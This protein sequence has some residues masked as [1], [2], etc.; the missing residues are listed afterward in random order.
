M[1]LKAQTVIATLAA[2]TAASANYVCPAALSQ[3]DAPS[4]MYGYKLQALLEQYY[5]SVPLNATFFS[6][7][8]HAD[9]MASNGKTLAEN[10]VTN[11]EGLMKQAMLGGDAT[12]ML[13]K[14]LGLS[15]GQC[16]FHMPTPE[17]GMAHL[18]NIFFLEATMCGAFIGLTD[19][20]QAPE[21]AF[22]T[23]RLS[24][25]HGIHASAI[26]AMMQAV[27]FMPNSTMLTPA[28]TPEMIISEG[29][30]KTVGQLGM[31]L[32]GCAK[33]PD[34]PCGGS[35][36][37]GPL[38]STLSG[39]SSA[40]TGMNGSM[41]TGGNNSSMSSLPPANA[42]TSTKVSM[43]VGALAAAAAVLF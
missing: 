8:P 31:W 7:L 34:A 38:I 30:G 15:P 41:T 21:V 32:N 12:K 9:M 37:I 2:A 1:R 22:L 42:G 5:N 11:V 13:G 27:G 29:D 25:E 35:V 6:D 33:A 14:M 26:R 3:T 24:A 19:Y 17:N 39:T 36:T 4:I 23:A 43:A 20:V 18:K 40:N 16:D 28:F 10:T